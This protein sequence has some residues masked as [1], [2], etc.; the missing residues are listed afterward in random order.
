MATDLHAVLAL[1][2]RHNLST[3]IVSGCGCGCVWCVRVCVCVA[4][5]LHA[6]LAL[7][8][9]HSLS[10]IIV[11]VCCARVGVGVCVGLGVRM[12]GCLCVVV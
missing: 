7:A 3:I 9:H 11:S 8:K 2:K 10:T 12:C 4:T 6:V 5:D 1:A